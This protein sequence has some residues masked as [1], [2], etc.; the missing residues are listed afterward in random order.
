M[1]SAV[2]RPEKAKEKDNT[3]LS[4]NFMVLLPKHSVSAFLASLSW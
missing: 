2:N 1:F 3:P 4:K